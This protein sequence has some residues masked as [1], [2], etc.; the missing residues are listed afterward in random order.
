[1]QVFRD[2]RDLLQAHHQ[3]QDDLRSTQRRKK[4]LRT[5]AVVR[6]DQL[7]AQMRTLR[8]KAATAQQQLQFYQTPYPTTAVPDAFS[9]DAEDEEDTEQEDASRME[10]LPY[11]PDELDS[12]DKET[13][14][15]INQPTYDLTILLP[16]G[17]ITPPP[18]DST[19]VA[20]EALFQV[21]QD[22]LREF[23]AT[24]P[25]NL[26]GGAATAEDHTTTPTESASAAVTMVP[27]IPL[28]ISPTVA[29]LSM[30]SPGNF[31][32]SI[33]TKGQT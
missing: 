29:A 33:P 31:P 20:N 26:W 9:P 5:Q 30:L 21:A 27:P 23:F 17:P 16:Y 24:L 11:Q 1:M 13:A 2:Y 22:T 12:E 4:Q 15:P 10:T 28:K 6:I 8:H 18:D 14:Q 7:Q 32:P 19:P 25:N 3:L